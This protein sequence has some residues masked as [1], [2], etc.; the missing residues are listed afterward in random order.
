ME[1]DEG[2]GWDEF[3]DHPRAV[4]M[5]WLDRLMGRAITADRAQEAAPAAAVA[6]AAAAEEGDG[7]TAAAAVAPAAGA[8]AAAAPR[9]MVSLDMLLSSQ[10]WSSM[11]AALSPS[12]KSSA[13]QQPSSPARKRSVAVT[14]GPWGRRRESTLAGSEGSE[15]SSGGGVNG[16]ARRAP[17][18]MLT[19]LGSSLRDLVAPLSS[20]PRRSEEGG[21]GEELGGGGGGGGGSGAGGK[22]RPV[23]KWTYTA[24]SPKG[25]QAKGSSVHI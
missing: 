2:L 19:R 5:G 9:P 7:A 3:G 16:G 23:R 25:Q 1:D 6:P 17:V 15:G 22:A 10:R 12:N 11:G 8:A 14:P 18:P 21:D 24:S 4:Q 20:S 13:P